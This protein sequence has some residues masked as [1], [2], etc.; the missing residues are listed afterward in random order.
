MIIRYLDRTLGACKPCEPYVIPE[1][2]VTQTFQYP[3]IKQCTLTHVQDPTV[4]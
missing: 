3:V 1:T 4:I 2:I